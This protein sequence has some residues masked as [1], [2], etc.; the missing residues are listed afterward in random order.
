VAE[1]ILRYRRPARPHP[2]RVRRPLA[3]RQG[4]RRL[5]RLQR[6]RHLGVPGTGYATQLTVGAENGIV[7]RVP[8][9]EARADGELR[10]LSPALPPELPGT[11]S[12]VA[13][14]RLVGAALGTFRYVISPAP[15][16]Q[17]ESAWGRGVKRPRPAGGGSTLDFWPAKSY[18]K[19]GPADTAGPHRHIPATSA[20]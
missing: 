13:P 18:V 14:K 4:P 12:S 6:P 16:G 20:P 9:A 2:V 1:N 11:P 19:G 15:A 5:R 17:G 8:G 7:S 10:I 3:P